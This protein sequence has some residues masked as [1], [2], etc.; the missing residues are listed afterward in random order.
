MLSFAYGSGRSFHLHVMV[1]VAWA[2]QPRCDAMAVKSPTMSLPTSLQGLLR[3]RAIEAPFVAAVAVLAGFGAVLSDAA[4]TGTPIWDEFLNAAF[5]VIVVVAASKAP[6]WS[7]I[8]MSAIAAAASLSAVWA[9]GAWLALVISF[10][11][12][13]LNRRNRLIGAIAAGIA[14]Q[15]VLRLPS[16][17]FF[18]LQTVI[19]IAAVVPV[20]VFGYRFGT[21]SARRITR[22]SVAGTGLLLA[23]IGLLGGL[24]L[25][26]ARS[27]VTQGIT[28]ARTGMEAGRAGN[29]ES[30]ADQ[31]DRAEQLFAEASDGL[32]GF[33]ARSLRLVP[34]AAQHQRAIEE[35]VEQGGIV[36]AEAAGAVREANIGNVRLTAGTLDLNALSQMAPRLRSTSA[37]LDSAALKIRAAS[38]PWLAP[39]LSDRI[40]DLLDEVEDFQPDIELG[41]KAAEV[42]PAMLGQET[43][44][45]YF[46]MFGTPAESRELGGFLGSWALLSFDQGQLQLGES[47]RIRTLYD[48]AAASEVPP[49]LVSDWYLRM[50]RPTQFPQNLPSSPDMA[51]VAAVA[52]QVLAGA[53]DA[54]IDGFIYADGHALVDM[55]ELSGPVAIPDRDEPLT[56]VNGTDFFFDEQYR[57]D[58]LGRN[59]LFDN[60]ADVAA[61]VLASISGQT[62]P[63]PEELGRVMGP[64]ARGGHLQV[65][66]FDEQANEFLRSVKL[67]RNF[68]RNETLDFV[69][70]VQTNGLSNK[71][72]LYLHRELDYQVTVGDDG[73]VDAT[74]VVTLRS[75]VPSDPPTLALG[76]GATAGVN[77][78]LL[79]LYSPWLLD[80]VTVDGVPVDALLA[81]EFSIGRYLVEIDLLPNAAASVIEFRLNGSLSTSE[82]YSLEV[83]HQPLVN[84]DA[85]TVSAVGSEFDVSWNGQLVENV[86]LTSEE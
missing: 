20:L 73:R 32:T 16:V 70:L 69:G 33:G 12:V 9:V 82:P 34:I 25:L 51:Q 56:S 55:L 84:D 44:K 21:R 7:M 50:A 27:D 13:V 26:N 85:V 60:L 24:S 10:L 29:T 6:R 14:V 47:G 53:A 18:G 30:V 66:T 35:A 76:R 79:S 45:T 80:G 41:A 57:V 39:A 36:T 49:G 2:V 61:G 65:A 81:T 1:P 4:P 75:E 68:G 42:L 15:S 38:S 19:A 77:K 43:P 31:L 22:W 54:P 40:D 48:V 11:S 8:V 52:R 72:D 71:M 17:G 46:I 74:A 86:V 64:A 28:A 59:E 5:A 3:S 83:W 63:G 78:V 58:D 62:L 23:V 67:L 37:A